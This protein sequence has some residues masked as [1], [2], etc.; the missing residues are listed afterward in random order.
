MS[1]PEPSQTVTL[2]EVVAAYRL[3]RT[4]DAVLKQ[5]GLSVT[6]MAVLAAIAAHP[7]ESI[8]AS[9]RT[10]DVGPAA[11]TQLIDRFEQRGFVTR[12]PRRRVSGAAQGDRRRVIVELTDRGRAALAAFGTIEVER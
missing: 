6:L 7:G 2:D 9:L 1:D 3:V 8:S 5:H 10:L 12:V 11:V 4:V